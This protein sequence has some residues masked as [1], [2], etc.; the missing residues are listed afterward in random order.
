MIIEEEITIELYKEIQPTTAYKFY[1]GNYAYLIVLKQELCNEY[2]PRLNKED[3][4]RF[5]ISIDTEKWVDEDEQD[6]SGTSYYPPNCAL[7]S[8]RFDKVVKPSEEDFKRILHSTSPLWET[9]TKYTQNNNK[10]IPERN[11]KVTIEVEANNRFYFFQPLFNKFVWSQLAFEMQ[12]STLAD[13]IEERFPFLKVNTICDLP[14]FNNG[15]KWTLQELLTSY[16]VFIDDKESEDNVINIYFRCKYTGMEDSHD[17]LVRLVDKYPLEKDSY[18]QAVLRISPIIPGADLESLYKRSGKSF[19]TFIGYETAV[20]QLRMSTICYDFYDSYTGKHAYLSTQQCVLV[21][22]EAHQGK[23]QPYI[24]VNKSGLARLEQLKPIEQPFVRILEN[25][26]EE[27]DNDANRCI[28]V[29]RHLMNAVRSS[30]IADMNNELVPNDE[31]KLRN[32]IDEDV[33]RL[34][35]SIDV[36]LNINE[37]G[38]NEGTGILALPNNETG[39]SR[40]YRAV[41]RRFQNLYNLWISSGLMMRLLSVLMR[42]GLR[43]ALSCVI[44]ARLGV[45]SI[46]VTIIVCLLNLMKDEYIDAIR[47]FARATGFRPVLMCW[48]LLKQLHENLDM[49]RNRF[50][51]TV[52]R[53]CLAGRQNDEEDLYHWVI[54]LPMRQIQDLTLLVVTLLPPFAQEYRLQLQDQQQRE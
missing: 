50:I 9:E 22:T 3:A 35:S 47:E 28:T 1:C 4:L 32:L 30:V 24:L 23:F 6:L 29:K 36:N 39:L 31:R 26:F 12:A 19:D 46:F 11:V 17:E 21:A 5:S 15:S 25:E 52:I 8:R 53:I 7:L 44:L 42:Y 48:M 27:K 10:S 13:F 43:C 37:I 54:A 34:V 51:F 18:D 14:L 38:N 49:V 16:K 41:K 33:L 40:S 20:D 45:L 2:W